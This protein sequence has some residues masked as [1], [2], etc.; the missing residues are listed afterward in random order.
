MKK[1][2][3]CCILF[4]SMAALECTNSIQEIISVKS[5]QCSR[6][7]SQQKYYKNQQ[8]YQQRT[9]SCQRGYREACA[10]AQQDQAA[11]QKHE[12]YMKNC[13]YP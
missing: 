6:S 5:D 4:A 2:Y 13:P 1:F 8:E 11:M 7:R 3:L 12:Y 9:M 10:K